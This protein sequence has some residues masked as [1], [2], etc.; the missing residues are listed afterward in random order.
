MYG[1]ILYFL[2]NG[3]YFP[4]DIDNKREMFIT[5]WWWETFVIMWHWEMVVTLRCWEMFVTMWRREMFIIMQCYS[6]CNGNVHHNVIEMLVTMRCMESCFTSYIMIYIFPKDIDKK[7]EMFVK[8][9][10]WET[11]V[12]MRHWEMVVT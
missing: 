7:S 9:W 6:Q 8:L 4:K 12:T 2:D 5:L 3:L 10:R 11:F 1:S